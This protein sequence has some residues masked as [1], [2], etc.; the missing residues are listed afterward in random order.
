MPG[1]YICHRHLTSR[2]CGGVRIPRVDT[3]PDRLASETYDSRPLLLLLHA[4]PMDRRMWQ[5]QG[6]ELCEVAR[7]VAV[8]LP[9]FG[10]S[11]PLLGP[12]RM[13]AW[14]DRLERF[15]ARVSGSEPVVVCGL[16]MGGYVAQRLAARHPGRLRA[17]VLADTRAA[18]DNEAER[19]A[20][21]RAIALVREHGVPTLVDGLLPRLFSPQAS[22]RIVAHARRLMDEQSPQGV[23]DALATMRDRHDSS[24][25]LATIDVPTLLLVG[26]ADE[27]TPVATAEAMVEAIPDGRLEVIPGAG[28]L[29]NMEA[30]AAF[31]LALGSFLERV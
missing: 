31:N 19:K 6:V 18:A 26:E 11:P 5:P 4:F 2:A 24:A 9:G 7:V 21:D 20:R 30:A 16:S 12:Q 22:P 28:H 1:E 23:M 14:V 8:D 13:D 3:L 25:C 15:I 10:E 29:S 17:L 27:L